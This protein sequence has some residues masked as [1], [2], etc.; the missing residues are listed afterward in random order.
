MM[1]GEQ[2]EQNIL[3]CL[4]HVF[5]VTDDKEKHSKEALHETCRM[6]TECGTVEICY[7]EIHASRENIQDDIAT[8][9]TRK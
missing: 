4:F 3:S 2:T 1:V 9:T 7:G 6:K 5:G 8:E